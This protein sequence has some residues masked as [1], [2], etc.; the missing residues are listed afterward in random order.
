MYRF[1]QPKYWP[2]WAGVLILR[3]LTLLPHRQ[4]LALG[5]LLGRLAFRLIPSRRDTAAVNL[6]LCFP[7][8][9]EKEI[10]TLLRKHFESLGMGVFELAMCLWCSDEEVAELTRIDGLDNL[11]EAL[12]DGNG[13]VVLSGHFAATELTGRLL[14]RSIPRI[15]AI[16]RPMKNAL[17]DEF[18]RRGRHRVAEEL[19][20][21][22]AMRQLI[23]T[24]KQGLPVWYA[25]DQSYNGKYSVLVPFFG[26]PAMTNAAL[27][28]IARISK[29]P[30]VTYFPRRLPDGKGYQLDI[31][32]PLDNF[33]SDDP[34]ADAIRINK[35]LEERIRLA[36]E[37]YYWVHRR[38][39]GRPDEYPNPYAKPAD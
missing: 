38:F 23:R 29:A 10:Q 21:K 32:P 16:Y 12:R 6:R 4:R 31:M 36:P 37:Q 24:L 25:P 1:W 8:L 34:E 30:V 39:K 28:H 11:I 14:R 13:A 5:R 33:P 9:E 7:K 17:A 15:A 22:D 19:I 20:P 18:I 3:I 27:T 26:E 35:L 2:L